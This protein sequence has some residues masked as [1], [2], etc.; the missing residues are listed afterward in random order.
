MSSTALIIQ[1]IKYSI[2]FI[3]KSFINKRH[4]NSHH[5]NDKKVLI[6]IKNLESK[7]KK[8]NGKEYV[9]CILVY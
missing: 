6:L 7:K 9:V 4:Y 5:K 1:Y 8:K 3:E 2:S